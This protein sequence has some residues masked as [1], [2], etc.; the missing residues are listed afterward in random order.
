MK[1]KKIVYKAV[2]I[3]FAFIQVISIFT[4]RLPQ[5]VNATFTSAS[6][7]I[8]NSRLS[9]RGPLSAVSSGA[10]TLT[11]SGGTPDGNTQNLFPKDVVCITNDVF[12]GCR[13]AAANS[14]KIFSVSS[15]TT[16]NGTT[17]TLDSPTTANTVVGD[18]A[19]ATQSAVHTIVFTTTTSVNGGSGGY[20]IIKVPAATSTTVSN[21]GIP[22]AT[23][24]DLGGSK[25]VTSSDVTCSGGAL[26]WTATV[27][28]SNASS[29]GQHEIKC[30]TTST[31]PSSTAMTVTI[32]GATN[33]LIN[34]APTTGHTRGQADVYNITATEYDSNNN[35]I[36]GTATDLSVAPIDGVLVSANLQN[37]LTFA[38]GSVGAG[39]TVC[40]KAQSVATTATT[41]PFG[42][43]SNAGSAYYAS[44][45]V[46]ISTN[47]KNGYQVTA[48]E[49]KPLSIDGSGA[50]NLADTTCPSNSC[51]STT[52]ANWTDTSTN[53]GFGYALSG[54][55][56]VF[57]WNASGTSFT[58]RSFESATA[59]AIMSNSAAVS[60]SQINVCYKLT[61]SA[62]QA[63]GYYFNKLTYIATATFE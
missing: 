8:S 22:D 1:Y 33:R 36:N 62:T 53:S 32:G 63:P 51:T 57:S 7:T 17:F 12:S 47:A 20:F 4:I 46:T 40:G 5:Q 13:G 44:H 30:S 45:T 19:V 60:N 23:G 18:A 54:N 16:Y 56:A 34:P 9:F 25:A 52:A 48:L 15:V 27:T 28:A 10:T 35:V 26:S 50:T 39:T 37:Y 42:S 21:D 59:R 3:V 49:D 41:V 38:I 55:D 14:S 31:I 11:L 61:I 29:S 58:A 2:V 6:D 43:V 24:F